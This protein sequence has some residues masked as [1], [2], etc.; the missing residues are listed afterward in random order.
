MIQEVLLED[1]DAGSGLHLSMRAVVD[2][3][4]NVAAPTEVK[5]AAALG[6]LRRAATEVKQMLVGVSASCLD[7]AARADRSV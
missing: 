6:V 1:G 2:P 5:M 3:P 4:Q 7:P